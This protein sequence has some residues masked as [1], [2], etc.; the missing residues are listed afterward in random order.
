[1]PLE[2]A[3]EEYISNCFVL[4]SISTPFVA[5]IPKDV[6]VSFLWEL[7]VSL[8]ES[9]F[10]MVTVAPFLTLSAE[11]EPFVDDFASTDALPLQLIEE[12]SI[13]RPLK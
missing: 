10:L 13:S 5:R 4:M 6:P 12:L 9:P 3:P 11:T 7:E 2:V 1:M 8:T